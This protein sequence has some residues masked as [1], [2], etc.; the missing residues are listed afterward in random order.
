[1]SE[2]IMI[3]RNSVR[4][5][6]PKPESSNITLTE[7]QRS[8][9]HRCTEIENNQENEKVEFPFLI[10]GTKPGSGKS[11]VILSYILA[12]KIRNEENGLCGPGNVLVVPANLY[13]QWTTYFKTYYKNIS[14]INLDYPQYPSDGSVSILYIPDDISLMKLRYNIHSIHYANIILI[15]TILYKLFASELVNMN[16]SIYRSIFDEIDSIENMIDTQFPSK[17][18]WFVTAS[19]DEQKIGTYSTTFP[20]ADLNSITCD[21]DP[22]FVNEC[23]QIPDHTTNEYEC[24]DI[25]ID[26]ARDIDLEI[27]SI[28]PGDSEFFEIQRLANIHKFNTKLSNVNTVSNNM[29]EFM[30]NYATDLM[31]KLRT[32]IETKESAAVMLKRFNIGGQNAGG[33]ARPNFMPI[34]SGGYGAGAYD[35]VQSAKNLDFFKSNANDNID[36]IE[37]Y[38]LKLALVLKHIKELKYK[39][40]CCDYKIPNTIEAIVKLDRNEKREISGEYCILC[41]KIFGFVKIEDDKIERD[42]SIPIK[43][44]VELE[45]VKSFENIPKY[46]SK[47][48]TLK[49]IINTSSIMNSNTKTIVFCDNS[50]IFG[51]ITEIGKALNKKVQSLD[52]QQVKI[53]TKVIEDF[54]TNDTDMLLIESNLYGCGLNL[55]MCTD[56]ILF[57]YMDNEYQVIGRA[58]RPGRKSN[59]R[60]H[61]LLYPNELCYNPE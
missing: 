4:A 56:L 54:G 5:K 53:V 34:N 28:F 19:F 39:T 48:S 21:C 8:M 37:K 16:I 26:R 11:Y 41:Q 24:L 52:S 12:E 32:A 25:D 1:M 33:Q 38:R 42:Y 40:T 49:Y 10:L 46:M 15:P 27:Q 2:K 58:Q 14:E 59:L 57:H 18:T 22:D 44:T 47:I 45:S 43:E 31:I 29:V 9:L 20:F 17:Y 60:V 7:H 50:N 61:K 23:L 35:P 36:N 55:E 13:A 3:N 51:K 6:Q 30:L